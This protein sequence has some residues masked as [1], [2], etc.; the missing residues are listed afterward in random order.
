[1]DTD[2]YVNRM[3]HCESRLDDE[4]IY[5]V[6]R[7]QLNHRRAVRECSRIVQDL[8]SSRVTPVDQERLNKV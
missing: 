1:M 5:L 8:L 7:R 3:W 4:V 2:M 6:R